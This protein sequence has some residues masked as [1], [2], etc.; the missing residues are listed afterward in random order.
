MLSSLYYTYF[1][2]KKHDICKKI[3][4][5][6]STREQFGFISL[7]LKWNF[8]DNGKLMCVS[9]RDNILEYIFDPLN[10]LLVLSSL[11]YTYFQ[12]K[13]HDICKKIFI[14]HSTREQFGFISLV[15]KWNFNDNGKLMCVSCRDNILEYIFDPL[16]YFLEL[17]SFIAVRCK[18]DRMKNL[19]EHLSY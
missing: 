3:F 13:K 12:Y 5:Y 6:H 19:K 8:N 10:Y 14:Y 18:M 7:V 2:Y 16:N 11:Y 4:I 1:Q 15:L 17:F 9:C